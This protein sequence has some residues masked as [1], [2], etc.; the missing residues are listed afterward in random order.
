MLLTPLMMSKRAQSSQIQGG[1][2][3]DAQVEYDKVFNDLEVMQN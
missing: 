1:N 3:D 2:S